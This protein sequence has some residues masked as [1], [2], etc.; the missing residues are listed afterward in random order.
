MLDSLPARLSAT[1]AAEQALR[2]A[3]V[4]G[5]LAPGDRLPPER[6][7]S[8]RLGVSRLTLRAALATLAAAGLISVRHGSGYTVRDLRDTGG[9]DLLAGIVEQATSRRG[10]AE[11]AT[12]LLRLR[13]HL[14]AAVLEAIAERAPSAANRRAVRAAVDRF[15]EA[16]S[17]GDLAAIVEADLGVVRA[18][19][20][21]TD[22]LILRVCLNPIVAVLRDNAP[23]RVAM[24]VAPA[25]N[26]AGWRA[27]VE[28]L[29][30]PDAATIPVLLAV[31]GERDRGT[32][33]RLKQP[34]PGRGD[35]RSR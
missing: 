33:Q 28:W 24:F 3:I 10:Q 34:R 25:T 15:E 22:S 23:L 5:E 16:A 9:S 19:L 18:L 11:A 27:L 21:A 4:S 1:T 26:L 6:V 17:R 35:R 13:R 20:D 8:T 14:A 29:E 12:D 7:L 2:T 30:H 32:V 31:L